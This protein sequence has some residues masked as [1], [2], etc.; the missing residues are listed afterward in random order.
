L[1]PLNFQTFGFFCNI[2]VFE[3]KSEKEKKEKIEN[4]LC[5]Y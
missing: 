4:E 3:G 5:H 1:N 2:P